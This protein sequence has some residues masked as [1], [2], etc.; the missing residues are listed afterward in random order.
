MEFI[1]NIKEKEFNN[2]V[3]NHKY[4]HFLKSYEWGQ[5]SSIKGWEPFYVGLKENKKL[6]ATA[7]LLKKRLPFGYSYFYI[8]RGYTIDYN[9]YELIKEFT[10]CINNFTKKHK[11]IFFKIDPDIKLHNIDKNANVT[12]GPNNYKLVNELKK[13]G[14]KRKKLNK[15]FENEQPRYT[16]RIELDDIEGIDKRYS[17]T[18]HRFIK[19]SAFYDVETLVGTKENLKDFTRLMKLTEKRQNFYSHNEEYYSNFFDVFNKKDHVRIMM[20]TINPKKIV[21]KL[22]KAIS[23]EKKSDVIER[24]REERDFFASK[25]EENIVVSSYITVLY[26]N[27]AWYLYGANDMDYKMTYANYK[28]FDYQIKQSLS[29][30]KEIFDEFGTIGSPNSDSKLAGLHEFKKKFGG[31]YV[32]FI[33]E[34]DYIQ[35]NI[36]NLLYRT[37]IPI[38]RKIVRARL[39]AKGE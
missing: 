11:S 34:F 21:E 1:E 33:G 4:S 38:R 14:F 23:I 28:L 36:V 3:E 39:R 2:F 13:I 19:K 15:F 8:P 12:E 26:G 9:N 25:V 35:N 32:E 31:E 18:V 17:K 29:D 16:F 30:G 10:S 20:A 37:L 27:K 7:L 5:I 6:L 22:D 24:K